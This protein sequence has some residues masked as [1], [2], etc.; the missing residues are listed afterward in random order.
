MELIETPVSFTQAPSGTEAITSK[1]VRAIVITCRCCAPN[2]GHHRD[3]QAFFARLNLHAQH[4]MV[5]PIKGG[6]SALFDAN[7][8]ALESI[9]MLIE[10]YPTVTKFVALTDANCQ[11][12]H[13][14]VAS[15]IATYGQLTSHLASINESRT[16][17][18]RIG[19][20][21]YHDK[22]DKWGAVP[23]RVPIA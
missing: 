6:V 21:L 20:E 11:C 23:K 7:M 1:D 10:K 15:L 18:H 2:A 16:H 19:I 8:N 4:A 22:H 9:D 13:N 14:H 12:E 17:Q 3:Y 5:F